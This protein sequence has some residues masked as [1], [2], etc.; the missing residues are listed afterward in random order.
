VGTT[1]GDT[2]DE[3]LGEVFQARVDALLK[4]SN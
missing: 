3:K 2:Y 1:L 4:Q